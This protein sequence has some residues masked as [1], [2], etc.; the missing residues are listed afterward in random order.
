MVTRSESFLVWGAG[1]HGRVVGDVLRAAGQTLVG[2]IDMD[3]K[4]LGQVIDSTGG[5]V[6]YDEE[7]FMARI[8]ER[9]SYPKGV[10]AIALGIGSNAFRLSRLRELEGF[11]VPPIIHPSASVSPIAEV[12]RGS[13]VFP[14]AVVNAGA[15]I[16]ES[17]IV[18]SGAIVE[19]DCR[20]EAGV[21]ISPGAVLCGGVI[22]GERSW[23]GAGATV[24]HG[25]TIGRDTI[26]GAGS[27]VIHDVG[28]SLT[29]IGSPARAC[30]FEE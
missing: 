7:Q 6:A 30:S 25:V 24:I 27:T 18:N 2:Y 12:S 20:L 21:H 14:L 5:A 22:V 8:R 28:D 11:N 19:H 16:G 13:V 15:W 1:G 9:S 10:D 3:A 4:K 26:V 23:I 17:V 29:V